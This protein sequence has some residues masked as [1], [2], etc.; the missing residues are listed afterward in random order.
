M[1]SLLTMPLKVDTSGL[2]G[3]SE[4]GFSAIRTLTENLA[5]N[6]GGFAAVGKGIG[7]I[8]L[9]MVA[10]YYISSILDGGR[11]Q[12]K[13]LV[14]LLI[15]VLVCNFS[16]V[17]TP[18]VSFT[19]TL[20][21]SLVESCQ[22]SSRSARAEMNGTSTSNYHDLTNRNMAETEAG[23]KVMEEKLNPGKSRGGEDSGAVSAEPKGIVAR[24]VKRGGDA[25]VN[26]INYDVQSEVSG[27]TY[28]DSYSANSGGKKINSV[29]LGFLGLVS[30]IISVVCTVMS[31]VLRAFGGIMTAVIVAFG[32]ITWA[33]AIIP[34][35]GG[36]I[37]SWFLRLCQFALYAPLAALVDSFSMQLFASLMGASGASLL[38]SIVV[39]LCNLVV[40]TSIPSIASM[41]IEGAQGSLALSQGMQSVG[42]NAAAVTGAAAAYNFGKGL[43]KDG[44]THIAKDKIRG[45][46]GV[47]K[48]PNGLGSARAAAAGQSSGGNGGSGGAATGQPSGGGSSGGTAGQPSGLAGGGTAGGDAGAPATGQPSGPSPDDAGDGGVPAGQASHG[49]AADA[50]GAAAAPAQGQPSGPMAEGQ[51]STFGAMPSGAG[52][53]PAGMPS[54]GGVKRPASGPGSQAGSTTEGKIQAGI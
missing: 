46:M 15:F 51:P 29:S 26:N 34:G 30:A 40:L 35:Q 44:V 25:L 20:T 36:T 6:S 5:S 33:F 47:Q 18:V 23:R 16:W 9:L 24:G 53:E 2:Y 48:S 28:A 12:L 13:M 43:F 3:A 17:S 54:H 42:K 21:D 49:A 11:F 32:P 8:M 27:E 50:S 31:L 38:M 41:I 52:G 22:A 45:M 14:P 1:L 10:V 39:A 19:T 4:K 37:K 7:A